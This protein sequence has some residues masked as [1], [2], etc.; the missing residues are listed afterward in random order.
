MGPRAITVAT[1]RDNSDRK[2]CPYVTT[3]QV[4][5]ILSTPG[6]KMS[7]GKDLRNP[8]RDGSLSRHTERSRECSRMLVFAYGEDAWCDLS[9]I[10]K[11]CALLH[12]VAAIWRKLLRI[13]RISSSLAF[14][15]LGLPIWPTKPNGTREPRKT[16]GTRRTGGSAEERKTGGCRGCQ[17][18]IG[19]AAAASPGSALYPTLSPGVGVAR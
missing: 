4:A 3:R 19:E 11:S 8:T 18:R 7:F 17:H 16:F 5:D 9:A 15:Q 1:R 6:Y 2:N 10:R 13:R 12:G 14:G